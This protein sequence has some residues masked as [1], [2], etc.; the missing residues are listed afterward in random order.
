[1][2]S[3]FF[4]LLWSLNSPQYSLSSLETTN[5][6]RPRFCF[7]RCYGFHFRRPPCLTAAISLSQRKNATWSPPPEGRW[8][9]WPER[10]C[11]HYRY[12]AKHARTCIFPLIQ[13]EIDFFH[14]CLVASCVLISVTKSVSLTPSLPPTGATPVFTFPSVFLTSFIPQYFLASPRSFNLFPFW[15]TFN[16]LTSCTIFLLISRI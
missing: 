2:T 8:T 7:W 14:V 16:F 10:Q 6:D 1:M 9:P 11:P 3:I 13:L 15:L 5:F 12:K 4:F